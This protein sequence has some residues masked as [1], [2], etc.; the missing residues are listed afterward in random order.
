MLKIKDLSAYY[1]KAQILYDVSMNVG[2]G[3]AVAVLGPNGAGKTTLLNSICGIVNAEGEIS[4]DGKDLTKLRPH[5]RMRGG[6]SI[7]PEGRRLFPNMSVEDNLLLGSQSKKLYE[8]NVEYI[9]SLFPRLKERRKQIVR[10]M[11]GGEQQMVAIGRALMSKPKL[12]MLDE[13]SI[14]LAPIVINRISNAIKRIKEE[15]RV[16][17]LLVEQNVHLAMD[18]ADRVYILVKGRVV[19]EGKI[20]ELH[21]LEEKYLEI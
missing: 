6:I 1:D 3:E 13:P 19:K 2:E 10:T 9:F 12:L 7:C 16:S 8:K 18:V 15:L 4:L 5:D 17:I 14:G 20:D 21:G 11:S